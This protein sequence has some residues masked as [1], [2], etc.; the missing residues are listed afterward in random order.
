VTITVASTG[1]LPAPW[2]SGDIG[3]VGA[4]GSASHAGGQFTVTA[5]GR[6]IWLDS[7]QFHYVWQPWTGDGDIVARID[8]VQRVTNETIGG[9]MF[10]ESLAANS[11]NV[12]MDV[13][14]GFGSVLQYREVTQGYTD[15]VD[16]PDETAPHW[17]KLTRRGTLFSG[18]L[19]ADGLSW[20]LVGSVNVAMAQQCFVGLAAC[21]TNYFLGNPSAKTTV[22]FSQVA[23][24]APPS[25]APLVMLTSPVSGSMFSE[26]PM[27]LIEV[28]AADPA[29]P[30]EKVEVF[31]DALKIGEIA[32]PPYLFSWGGVVPGTY[33]LR[34]RATGPFARS[35]VSR[36]VEFSVS[37]R[38][39][40]LPPPWRHA[41]IGASGAQRGHAAHHDGLF[42]ISSGPSAPSSDADHFH[43]VWRSWNGDGE[44]R[45]RVLSVA[46]SGPQASAGVMFREQLKAGARHVFL[47]LQGDLGTSLHWRARPGRAGK[48]VSGPVVAAP[49]WLKLVRKGTRFSGYI[50]LDGVSWR[51]VARQT[52]RIGKE[53]SVGLA[54]SGGTELCGTTAVFERVQTTER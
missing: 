16:G 12:L 25:P 37:E 15:W 19:S 34:A 8:A 43:Y 1:G 27:I 26:E 47:D 54:V 13:T 45:A 50:S 4:A 23:V 35:A 33:T 6:D 5:A 52:V 3:A 9:V 28:A 32:R 11:N 38:E 30:I 14:A 40:S 10:R 44:I 17:V 39:A 49:R 48:S 29:G 36:P 46:N 18:W 24:N 21:A 22:I 31:H 20:R 41:D 42:T 53:C 2:R 51:L 7:D